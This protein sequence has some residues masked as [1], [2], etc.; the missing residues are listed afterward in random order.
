MQEQQTEPTDMDQSSGNKT[1]GPDAASNLSSSRFGGPP[2]STGAVLEP[3]SSGILN[4]RTPAGGPSRR[5]F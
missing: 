2:Q 3:V 4:I 5:S 1:T